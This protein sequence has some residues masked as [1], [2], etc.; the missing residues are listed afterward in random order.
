RGAVELVGDVPRPAPAERLVGR[1]VVGAV[2][3][4]ADGDLHP[5]AAV[6]AVVEHAE[7]GRVGRGDWPGHVRV[8]AR[9]VLHV[10]RKEVLRVQRRLRQAA[11]PEGRPE[12]GEPG[13]VPGDRGGRVAR[14]DR[15]GR[16]LAEYYR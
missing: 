10:Q 9:R 3:V 2:A 5:A 16:E 11:A 15:V 8:V 1:P 7:Q 14:I 4:G 12:P 6:Q 13:R